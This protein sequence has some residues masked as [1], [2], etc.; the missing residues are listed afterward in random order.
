ML[1]LRCE[2]G[3]GDAAAGQESRCWDW[4]TTEC[5][6]RVLRARMYALVIRVSVLSGCARSVSPQSWIIVA[7]CLVALDL[8]LRLHQA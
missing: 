8:N 2:L 5:D 6:E 1:H 7:A 3:A 4:D